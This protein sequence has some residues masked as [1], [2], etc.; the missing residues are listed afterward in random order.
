MRGMPRNHSLARISRYTV[1]LLAAGLLLGSGAAATASAESPGARPE[2][3]ITLP[4]A[5]S[6]EGIAAGAGS[7]FYAGDLFNGDIFRGDIRRG[8][9][10]RFID[11]PEGRMAVGMAADVRRGVLFVA[12]GA[13][14]QAYVYSTRTGATIA[15]IGLNNTGSSFINDV[16]LTASG[17]WFTDSAHATLYFVPVSQH[18]TPGAV[19]PLDVSGPA[20]D[21]SGDFNLNGIQA[22]R[23]GKTL[24]VSHSTTGRVYTVD[25]RTG[26][27]GLI[28]GIEVVPDG[29]V[30]EGQ[31][32]WVVENTNQISRFQLSA[33]L[34]RG[35]REKVITSPAFATTTTA[36]LFGPR[37]AAVNSHFD[38]GVPP[39][40]PTYEVVVVNS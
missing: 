17:A 7:T 14:G 19:H 40:S 16:A 18:G 33:D 20:G 10:K 15:T 39:T 9:A 27:S 12:G 4:G 31:Q 23:G 38:T 30:L 29:L 35:T 32:L 22:I 21:V 2:K 34:S 1:P 28:E 13:T 24:I 8:T 37:L 6:A 25:A 26:A 36:A 11:A 5:S 3:V